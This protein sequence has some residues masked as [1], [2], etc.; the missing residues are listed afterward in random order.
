MS[1]AIIEILKDIHNR[2]ETLEKVKGNQNVPNVPNVQS[3][4]NRDIDPVIPVVNIDQVVE[5]ILTQMKLDIAEA[6]RTVTNVLT[7]KFETLIQKKF[8]E[9]TE[10]IVM[11]KHSI[12]A[13]ESASNQVET[14]AL[15]S[16]SMGEVIED[17]KEIDLDMQIAPSKKRH[18]KK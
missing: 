3:V 12:S 6:K 15:L 11:L 16:Q 5:K 1:I 8:N 7:I 9:L 4:G 10:E 17:L 13:A 14:G 18:T 2:L